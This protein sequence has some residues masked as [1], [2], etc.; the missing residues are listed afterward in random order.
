VPIATM[1]VR[2]APLVG[3]CGIHAD[4]Q[5]TMVGYNEGGSGDGTD[6]F[7]VKGDWA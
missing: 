3:G 7:S 4:R 5:L 1:H 2:R 6:F